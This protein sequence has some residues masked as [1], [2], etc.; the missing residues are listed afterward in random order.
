MIDIA[1]LTAKIS[2]IASYLDE[3]R[4]L[5]KEDERVLIED[6]I[7]LHATER[8]FQ[9]VVD[10]AVDANTHIIAESNFVIPEDYQSTFITLAE[11]GILPMDFALRIAPSVGLR[12]LLIRRYGRVD[13]K[14]V[15]HDV[16][17]EIV[18]Y[19]EYLTHLKT[20]VVSQSH[21]A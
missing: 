16:K 5:L 15:V 20:F 18:Q 8:L 13:I 11:H 6:T 14:R 3:L 2:D 12:N 9:L 7:K 17:N 1:I 4:V 21:G 10:T 19:E